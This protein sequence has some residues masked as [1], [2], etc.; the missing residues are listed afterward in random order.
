MT[1]SYHKS[2]NTI[3]SLNDA[4]N[5]NHIRVVAKMVPDYNLSIV[6][7]KPAYH[8]ETTTM[9]YTSVDSD[10]DLYQGHSIGLHSPS[11]LFETVCS[12]ICELEQKLKDLD[13]KNNSN[14][15]AI[16]DDVTSPNIYSFL[17]QSEIRWNI[18]TLPDDCSKTSFLYHLLIL[19]DKHGSVV[20]EYFA[21]YTNKGWK[22]FMK[23][24]LNPDDE[25]LFRSITCN[26]I[27]PDNFRPFT[28]IYSVLYNDIKKNTNL[29]YT[30]K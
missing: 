7:E 2:F 4:D 19:L 23:K 8:W 6:P 16:L 28:Q 26:W 24:I 12:S 9:F 27:Y 10:L 14:R 13:A 11:E 15:Y 30:I 1:N 18:D 22:I 29:F 25:Y 5:T 3:K 20:T 21:Q 17:H